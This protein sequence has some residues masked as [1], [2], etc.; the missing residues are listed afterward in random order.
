MYVLVGL[1][2]DIVGLVLFNVDDV[3]ASEIGSVF[4]FL[5]MICAV[6][7]IYLLVRNLD[8]L[9]VDTRRIVDRLEQIPLT[10]RPAPSPAPAPAPAPA[11]T[12]APASQ[13]GSDGPSQLPA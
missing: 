3:V 8:L 6:V 1:A 7:G 10:P 13:V 11:S 4:L 12:P 5:G 9:A 2:V